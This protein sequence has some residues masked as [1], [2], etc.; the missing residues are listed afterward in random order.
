MS[1]DW[2]VA[3]VPGE[4]A[5]GRVAKTLDARE[6]Q[7]AAAQDDGLEQLQQGWKSAA[8]EALEK[9]GGEEESAREARGRQPERNSDLSMPAAGLIR[10]RYFDWL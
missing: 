4:G 2:R 7:A 6:Q 5:A 3:C 10:F 8:E 1:L 9:G